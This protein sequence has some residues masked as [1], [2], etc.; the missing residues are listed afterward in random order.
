VRSGI[1]EDA[2]AAMEDEHFD[3]FRSIRF[4]PEFDI[5]TLILPHPSIELLPGEGR[6][7]SR[8]TFIFFFP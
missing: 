7:M 1:N 6:L 2:P 8:H 5:R 4:V 3:D